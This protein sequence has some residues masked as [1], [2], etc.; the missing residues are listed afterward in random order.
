MVLHKKKK[1][2]NENVFLSLNLSYHITNILHDATA[3]ITNT[4]NTSG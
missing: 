3:T 2:K 1:K 4:N